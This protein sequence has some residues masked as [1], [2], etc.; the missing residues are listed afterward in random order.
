[1]LRPPC[2]GQ[3]LGLAK[4]NTCKTVTNLRTDL[5]GGGSFKS[6]KAVKLE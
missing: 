4:L 3:S 5:P 2:R 6:M 1:M